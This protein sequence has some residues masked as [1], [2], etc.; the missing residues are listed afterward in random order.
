MAKE[1]PYFKF[2]IGE[3]L[4][5]D[6]SLEDYRIQGVFICIC[7]F[8]WHNSCD[9]T[10]SRLFKRYKDISD[11]FDA[12]VKE[13]I[14]KVKGDKIT[15]NFLDEQW[16][17]K[18]VTKV[19]NRL[20]GAKG[21]RPKKQQETE[22]KPN[23]FFNENR[24]ESETQPKTN[25]KHNPNETNI[26]K[27]ILD[28]SREEESKEKKEDGFVFAVDFEQKKELA[29]AL[30]THFGFEEM[31]FDH[32]KRTINAFVQKILETGQLENFKEQFVKYHEYKKLSGEKVHNFSGLLGTPAMRFENAAWNSEN[33]QQKIDNFNKST[34]PKSKF[35][36]TT[37]VFADLFNDMKNGNSNL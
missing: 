23:G 3:Y 7:A 1:L 27:I 8:Y 10:T 11:D 4:N 37:D 17:S 16:N 13:N 25:P 19:I 12:L 33:W 35:E 6:I 32:H 15:I 31:R 18:E 30:I 22:N 26:D 29:D 24:N 14:I 34:G 20:N 2:V 9:L 21:G 5:G 36:K 28:Y